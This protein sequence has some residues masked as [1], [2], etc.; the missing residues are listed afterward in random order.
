MMERGPA[1]SSASGESSNS[2]YVD[3]LIDRIEDLEARIDSL[4]DTFYA[5]GTSVPAAGGGG[6]ALPA[7]M[8]E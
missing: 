2:A 4:I 7:R 3:T 6:G 1:G 8:N 5:A